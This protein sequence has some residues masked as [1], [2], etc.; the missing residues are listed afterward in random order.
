MELS[1][2]HHFEAIIVLSNTTAY[3]CTLFPPPK[4]YAHC[5]DSSALAQ[6]IFDLACL[7]IRYSTQVLHN[8]CR[9]LVLSS[10]GGQ[11]VPEVWLQILLALESAAMEQASLFQHFGLHHFLPHGHN[12]DLAAQV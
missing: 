1:H 6:P 7:G 12:V 8:A 5:I 10:P 4:K 11:N 3:Q 9:R 2:H